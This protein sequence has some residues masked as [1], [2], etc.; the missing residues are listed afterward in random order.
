MAENYTDEDYRRLHRAHCHT[1]D[2][3]A[4]AEATIAELRASTA[5]ARRREQALGAAIS[6]R[7]WSE[8]EAAHAAIRDAV[9]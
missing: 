9:E 8:V 4:A 5:G 2:K 1:S 3:L 6:R 7:E